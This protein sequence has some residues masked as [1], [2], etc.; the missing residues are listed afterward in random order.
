[1][2]RV[3]VAGKGTYGTVYN[4]QLSKK[5]TEQ[6][7]VKRNIVDSAIS[8]SGCLRELDLLNRLRGHPYIVKLHSI[9]FGN[10]FIA[11]NSPISDRKGALR[12]DYL[13]FI[14]EK[15]EKN[16][17]NLIY[18]KEIHVGYLK[19]AMAQILLSVEYM[20]SK[21]VMHRDIK[22]ANLLW[23]V[24]NEQP[25]V[26][27]CD[28]GLS[29]IKCFGE[30][31]SP[32]VVTCW[33]RAP[34]ICGRETDYSFVSDIWSVGCVFYEMISKKALL[35]GSKDDDHYLLEKIRDTIPLTSEDREYINKKLANLVAKKRGKVVTDSKKTENKDW[36]GLIGLSQEQINEFNKYPTGEDIHYVQFLDLLS[37]MMQP[38]PN[39]RINAT[40]ALN[41]PFFLPYK[42]II[43]WSRSNFPPVSKH[44]HSLKI[45]ECK[46]RKWS[47]KLAFIVF[48]NRAS[49]KWYTHRILFQ[50]ID[51]FDRYLEYMEEECRNKKS[52]KIEST[53]T[54]K[55]LTRFES[56][57]RYLVCLYMSI[58]YFTTLGETVS[59]KDLAT[60]EYKTPKCMIEAEE[61][62]QKM[63]RDIL[64]FKIYRETI[65]EAADKL[66]DREEKIFNEVKIRD[67][68]VLYGNSP[69]IENITPVE[70]LK[71]YLTNDSKKS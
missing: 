43:D 49:L 65:F 24:E 6:I 35:L 59:F 22:P 71:K 8:F 53:Q 19:L 3:G 30:P 44:E 15:G 33:Y 55:M 29:K 45:I 28:F 67:I 64:K 31:S 12:E 21:G 11:P 16:L 69:S 27:L 54:G 51:M 40:D 13:H 4:A 2:I 5:D 48:N 41:H 1:M 18:E 62:E 47:S 37:K 70:L 39:K 42:N 25:S 52:F 20:H 7:A 26:K 58:K 63:I 68:L 10:P 46:E 36:K 23:F 66:E 17:H 38:M 56:H 61:F 14:F 32:G 50:S 60:D 9:S 34:E 57:L